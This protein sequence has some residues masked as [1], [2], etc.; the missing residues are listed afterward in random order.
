[1]MGY[2]HQPEATSETLRDGWLHTGDLAVVDEEGYV[3]IVDR[4]KDMI[5]V[6]GFN[7][8]PREV[9]ETLYPLSCG[10]RC[11][12][13]P[14]SRPIPGRIGDGVCRAQAGATGFRAGD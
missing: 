2:W 8:Y 7:V 9:E 4:K 5:N 13:G 1:M 10:C 12:G 14:V 11:R 6:S 3:T